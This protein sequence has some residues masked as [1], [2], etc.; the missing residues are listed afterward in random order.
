MLYQCNFFSNY[1]D[2][3]LGVE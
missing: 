2:Y 3:R 1:F